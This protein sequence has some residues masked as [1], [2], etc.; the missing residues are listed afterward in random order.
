MAKPSKESL[1]PAEQYAQDVISGKIVACKWVRLAC[2]RHAHDLKHA[3]KRG[4]YFDAGAAEYVLHFIG[5]LRHSKGKWGRGKGEFIRLEPWQQFIIWVAFGWKRKADGMRRFRVLYEEVARKNGKSTKAAGLG[6]LLAF[7]DNEPGAEVYSAATKRDQARIVHKE[8]IR[9]VRKNAGLKKYINIVKDNLNLEQRACKYE[10][11]GADSDS[12]D[13]LNVHGVIADELHAWKSR[14]MWDV[15]ETATGSREQPMLI[16]ITTA[17]MDRQSICYEK[18]EYTRKVLE[19]WKDG[20]FEDDSWFGI[21]FTLDDGD[22]WR[23]EKVWIKANPNLGVSKYLDDMRMKAKRAEK[24]PTS[25]NNFKRR[26]LNIWVHGET[27]WMDMEAWRKCAGEIAALELPEHLKGR[28]GYFALDLSSTSD[29]TAWVG[30]FPAEDGFYDVIARFWLPEDAILPRTQEGTHY[31]VWVRE[32]Y[33]QKTD[34]NVLDYDYIFDDIEQD[35]DDY[36]VERSAFDRWGAARVVQV[37]E[38]K[39]LT[40]VQF[41]QG[42]ASMNPPMKELERLVL[43]G[44]LRHGNNPVL[45]WMADNVV[46]SMDPAG[47]IKPD[48]DKSKEKIDGI[49]ALIM[50]LD[51]ALRRDP[52]QDMSAIM[53]KDYGM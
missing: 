51:L 31:D 19:G 33:I 8:A 20:S 40:M 2:E 29:L 7:A 25:Q 21:I 34:G 43:A 46:A 35:A 1:H 27:K 28:T 36:S 5:M 41:G 32:G 3:H 45:T 47:N 23:D 14:E 12:T 26:E 9:M 39:G 49:V 42:Y 13:G 6:L 38:K 16:A 4:L 48:K 37:L 44:K 15:L 52:A 11:L 10:P 24:M 22:D 53:S 18:H 50:A 30:A 17:G